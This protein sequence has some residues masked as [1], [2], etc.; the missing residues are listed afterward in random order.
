MTLRLSL[1]LPASAVNTS[2]HVNPHLKI[3]HF[4]TAET[5]GGS[6][7]AEQSPVINS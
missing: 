3:N 4:F 2:M 5:L 7:F 6:V 1:P